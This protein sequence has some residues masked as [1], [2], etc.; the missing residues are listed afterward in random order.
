[1]RLCGGSLTDPSG[2]WIRFANG[3]ATCITAYRR[4][5]HTSTEPRRLCC[6]PLVAMAVADTH[7]RWGKSTSRDDVQALDRA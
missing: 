7:A 2:C 6:G 3:L 4:R 5:R 1:M